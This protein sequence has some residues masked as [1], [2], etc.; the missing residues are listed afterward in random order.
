LRSARPQDL[1][2]P[3]P[4]DRRALALAAHLRDRPEDRRDLGVLAHEV[5]ASPRTLQRLFPS[6]TGLTIEAWRRKARLIDA[7]AGLSSG[8]GVT[9][10]AFDCGYRNVGAF[11][12]AF[13]HQFGVT[14][15]RY[16][17]SAA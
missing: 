9:A 13:K 16:G 17:N 11:I 3:L 8:A 6:E 4:R 12:T 1:A 7:A 2:L 14:P 15:G 5:G 10:A